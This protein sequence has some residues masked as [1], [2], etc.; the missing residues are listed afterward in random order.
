MTARGKAGA[1]KAL[2]HGGSP[3]TLTRRGF[4][5]M[6]AAGSAVLLARPGLAEEAAAT[7][8]KGASAPAGKPLPPAPPPSAAQ[9]EFDRQ[10][11]GTLATL[12]TLREHPLPPGGDLPVVFRPQRA[13]KRG[14]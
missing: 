1:G 6:V 4:V 5:T 14:R 11:A 2:A 3:R 7:R 13:R 8:R 10:R 9:K 12:K